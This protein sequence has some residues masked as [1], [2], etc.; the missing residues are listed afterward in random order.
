MFLY[1]NYMENE[2]MQNRLY[3]PADN[4]GERLFSKDFFY[5]MLKKY[6]NMEYQLSVHA[7]GNRAFHEVVEIFDQI[8]KESPRK[9][10]RHRLE[11]CAFINK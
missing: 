9:D 1:E 10:H 8:L 2:I 4:H 11:H 7:Q 3:I 6:H 5:N